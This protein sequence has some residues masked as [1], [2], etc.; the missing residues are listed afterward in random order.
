MLRI[1]ELKLPLTA[2]PVDTRRAADAPSE[3][4][5]D[6]RPKA[7]PLEALTRMA[8]Q[9]HRAVAVVGRGDRGV[10]RVIFK[11]AHFHLLYL[12]WIGCYSR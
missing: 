11:N 1:T 10:E 8:A 3:T 7:H 4:D 2:L 5:E 9:T 6:R 12:S